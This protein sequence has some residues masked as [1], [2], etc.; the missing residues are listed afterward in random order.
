M[1]V[2][3]MLQIRLLQYL[4]TS[5]SGDW[6]LHHAQCNKGPYLQGKIDVPG[7][8]HLLRHIDYTDWSNGFI[9][10]AT[11]HWSHRPSLTQSSLRRGSERAAG[12]DSLYCISSGASKTLLNS[13]SIEKPM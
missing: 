11:T 5:A 12:L 10:S 3:S 1:V 8:L 13:L 9:Q 7:G 6:V 2:Y 4:P